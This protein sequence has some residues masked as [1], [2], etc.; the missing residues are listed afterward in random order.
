[1]TALTLASKLSSSSPKLNSIGAEI[2]LD[3]EILNISDV[4]TAHTPGSLLTCADYLS[5]VH[6]PNVNA[7]M[8]VELTSAKRKEVAVRSESFYRVWTISN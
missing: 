6:E 1:M 5:R 8:P 2:A 4:F 7:E 3:L